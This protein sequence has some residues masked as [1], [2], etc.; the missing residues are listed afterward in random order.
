M[1]LARERGAKGLR[2]GARAVVQ[3]TGGGTEPG[4]SCE[5]V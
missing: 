2:G 1:V 3:L 5:V 4:S